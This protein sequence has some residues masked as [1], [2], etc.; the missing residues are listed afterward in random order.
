MSHD[1][2]WNPITVEEKPEDILVDFSALDDTTWEKIKAR[3]AIEDAA[4]QTRS[5]QEQ[6]RAAFK[7]AASFFEGGPEPTNK[8]WE[9]IREATPTRRGTTPTTSTPVPVLAI[10]PASSPKRT[11]MSF[12]ARVAMLPD[13]ELFAKELA[14]LWGLTSSACSQF[15]QKAAD[16]GIC[17]LVREEKWQVRMPPRKVYVKV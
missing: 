8:E 13:G 14:E 6:R 7:A 10:A 4:R 9:L 17:K 3:I 15:L 5:K 12:E 1:T 16:K 2:V 11:R